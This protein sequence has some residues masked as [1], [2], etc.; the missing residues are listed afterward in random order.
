MAKS[1]LPGK[2]VEKK[3]AGCGDARG[4][5]AGGNVAHVSQREG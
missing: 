4:S 2:G 1:P 3:E 5:T